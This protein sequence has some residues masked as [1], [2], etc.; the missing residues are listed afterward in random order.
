[1]SNPLIKKIK[2]T[3]GTVYDLSVKAEN[4]E[5]PE[6]LATVIPIGLT[7]KAD[8]WTGSSAPYTQTIIFDT[9]F[10][11]DIAGVVGLAKTATTTEIAA[12]KSA[13]MIATSLTREDITIVAN[14]N[15][16]TV[17]IPITLEVPAVAAAVSAD[18]PNGMEVEW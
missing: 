11:H 17:D 7:L 15:K 2:F 12:A 13:D 14:G 1:M 18:L 5:N 4:I 10:T 3:D 8:S 9:V 6:S 16:P